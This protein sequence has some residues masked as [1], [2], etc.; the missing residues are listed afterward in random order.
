MTLKEVQLLKN[1]IDKLD[2]K[3]FDLEAWKNYSVILVERIFGEGN[4]RV[5]MLRDLHY[6]YSSWNLRDATGIGKTFDPVKKQAREILE[7]I[8]SELEVLGSPVKKNEKSAILGIIEEELTGKQMKELESIIQ[9]EVEA[10]E[11]KIGKILGTLEKE[12]LVSL[13]SRILL[14]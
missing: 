6:D 13:L 8:I 2:E 1:Q 12:K 10:R 4:T 14:C 5:K 3:K 7:A 11:E 9:S